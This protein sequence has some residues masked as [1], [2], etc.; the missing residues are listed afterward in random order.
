MDHQS[1]KHLLEQRISTLMEQKRMLKLMGFNYTIQYKT[2][3]ENAAADAL[4]RRG[5]GG[6]TLAITAVIPAW[7]QQVVESYKGQ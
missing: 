3:K 6:I 1:L 4:F 2:G 7:V 5:G